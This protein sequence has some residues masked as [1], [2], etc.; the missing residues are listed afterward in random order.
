[1]LSFQN[2]ISGVK[3]A[4]VSGAKTLVAQQKAQKIGLY[5]PKPA[6]VAKAATIFKTPISPALSTIV[7][8]PVATPKPVFKTSLPQ[9]LL[10]STSLNTYGNLDSAAPPKA[11]GPT[12]Q[13]LTA[14]VNPISNIF[15]K[16]LNPALSSIIGKV[17]GG[18]AQD[19][20]P[21]PTRGT[22]ETELQ[23]NEA[24]APTTMTGDLYPGASKEK[25]FQPLI[26]KKQIEGFTHEETQKMYSDFN[27]K[28]QGFLSNVKKTVQSLSPAMPAAS[29]AGSYLIDQLSGFAS[30]VIGSTAQM[31]QGTYEQANTTQ[32]AQGVAHQLSG[33]LQAGLLPMTTEFNLTSPVKATILA[34]VFKAIPGIADNLSTSISWALSGGDKQKQA[35]INAFANPILQTLLPIALMEGADKA[36]DFVKNSKGYE[37]L[38]TNFHD[39]IKSIKADPASFIKSLGSS[40]AVPEAANLGPLPLPSRLD[41][42]KA[43][44]TAQAQSATPLPS[45]NA[46]VA[47]NAALP[48]RTTLESPS[49]ADFAKYKQMSEGRLTFKNADDIKEILNADGKVIGLQNRAGQKEMFAEAPPS[50]LHSFDLKPGL[51]SAVTGE[52]ASLP[53]YKITGV[54]SEAKISPLEQKGPGFVTEKPLELTAPKYDPGKSDQIMTAGKADFGRKESLHEVVDQVAKDWH[55]RLA[56]LKDIPN[57]EGKTSATYLKASLGVESPEIAGSALEKAYKFPKELQSVFDDIQ[58]HRTWE[59]RGKQGLDNPGGLSS[60]EATA[61]I[62]DDF[63]RLSE[64]QKN[65][66]LKAEEATRKW[67]QDY[68]QKPLLKAGLTTEGELNKWNASSPDY[69]PQHVRQWVEQENL[70]SGPSAGSKTPFLEKVL[71]TTAQTDTDTFRARMTL[72]AQVHNAIA[73]KTVSDSAVKEWG[74]PLKKGTDPMAYLKA[75]PDKG[76]ITD[77]SGKK[78]GVP[79]QVQQVLSGLSNEHLGIVEKMFSRWASIKRSGSTMARLGFSATHLVRFSQSGPKLYMGGDYSYLRDLAPSFAKEVWGAVTGG[80]SDEK[81]EALQSGGLKGGFITT[82]KGNL[83]GTDFMP[84]ERMKTYDKVVSTLKSMNVI[85]RGAM[86]LGEASDNAIRISVGKAVDRLTPEK[87]AEVLNRLDPKYVHYVANPDVSPDE[88]K[89]FL[90]QKVPMDFGEMGNKMKIVNRIIPFIN[91][92]EKGVARTLTMVAND[93]KGAAIRYA[94]YAVLPQL[95]SI[96]WNRMMGGKQPDSYSQEKYFNFNTGMTVKDATGEDVPLMISIPKGEQG[97]ADISNATQSLFDLV[98]N[99]DPSMLQQTQPFLYALASG[100]D[101]PGAAATQILKSMPQVPVLTPILESL[102]NQ[103]FYRNRKITKQSLENV[104]WAKMSPEAMSQLQTPEAY[105]ALS[106]FTG[107]SPFQIQ[108]FVEGVYPA[109]NQ[110]TS[111]LDMV[112]GNKKWSDLNQ[113]V[114]MVRPGYNQ[115]K[116]LS[117]VYSSI[118]KARKETTTA[119]LNVKGTVD[120]AISALK[121]KDKKRALDILNTIPTDKATYAQGY[122]KQQLAAMKDTKAG[123][124]QADQ[125]ISGLSGQEAIQYYE[126][127]IKSTHDKKKLIE[128]LDKLNSRAAGQAVID[129]IVSAS[130]QH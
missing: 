34:P 88:L 127:N 70:A 2:I 57:K 91:M 106:Q 122:L 124:S 79:L 36:G 9:E 31:E 19:F 115:D 37:Q 97:I 103:D 93:P 73:R 102:T 53:K 82:E 58:N 129:H 20:N 7:S 43:E 27:T 67:T 63:S 62:Q 86:A 109:A 3:S 46:P 130:Q 56:P 68:I 33:I 16:A 8:G 99:K 29:F 65:I 96:G 87:Q 6:A 12:G 104:D 44:P 45:V 25:A 21:I 28:T 119:N 22:P 84:K 100:E 47:D 95:M 60:S 108:H 72:L 59:A 83:R 61:R 94:K 101:V 118:D 110:Y 126:A 35:D 117:E 26:Q 81:I 114:P 121:S 85:Y 92:T 111:A 14:P 10:N 1:M 17:T 4:A 42:A 78:Y 123:A 15:G 98:V 39:T 120:E 107:L 13:T 41:L 52:Q 32:K 54:K 75:N 51:K 30:G 55:D 38:T 71:G 23:M 90:M 69:L 49:S 105:K 74:D 5:A 66:I 11:E 18:K 128:F 125:A 116:G 112:T 113:F 77:A 24:G 48:G 76:I 40:A 89:A 80:K 64:P 50:A